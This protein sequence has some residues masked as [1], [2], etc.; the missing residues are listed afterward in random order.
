MWHFG[1]ITCLSLATCVCPTASMPQQGEEAIDLTH[2]F[3]EALTIQWPTA[4]KFNFTVLFRDYVA[5][6]R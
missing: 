5:P 1:A 2:P 6:D 3:S 4:N